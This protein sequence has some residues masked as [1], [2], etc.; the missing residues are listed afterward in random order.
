MAGDA[1]ELRALIEELWPDA[2]D[3]ALQRV[4][5][6]EA[7][8]AAVRMGELDAAGRDAARQEAHRLAGSL[9]SFGLGSATAPARALESAFTGDPMKADHD[10]LAADV[11][12]LRR[13]VHEHRP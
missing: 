7:A 1:D 11:A 8:V 5:V 2:R 10:A 4:R 13:V 9:G 12:H 6:I 3:R